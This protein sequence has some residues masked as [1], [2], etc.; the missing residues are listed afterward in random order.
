MTKA[1]CNIQ[2]NYSNLNK[3]TILIMLQIDQITGVI[4]SVLYLLNVSHIWQLARKVLLWSIT[5]LAST[6]LAF[7]F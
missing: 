2:Y 4:T 3:K 5:E 1:Y 7:N 6:I